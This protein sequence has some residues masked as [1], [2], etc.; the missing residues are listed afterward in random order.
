LV[1]GF[2]GRAHERDQFDRLAAQAVLGRGNVIVVSGEAGVGKTSLLD[3]AVSSWREKGFEVYGSGAA[4]IDQRRRFGLIADALRVRQA[5]DP[6][7]AEISRIVHASLS[8]PPSGGSPEPEVLDFQ[9]AERALSYIEERAVVA[10]V[11]LV[12]E[13]LQWADTS[14]LVAVHRLA[15]EAEQLRLLLV[16]TWLS[17][18]RAPEARPFAAAMRRLGATFFELKPLADAEV[19]QL[20]AQETG[21]PGGPRLLHLLASANGNP[22]YIKELVEALRSDGTLVIGADGQAEVPDGR[23]PPSLR[24]AVQHRL[25][26]LPEPTLEILRTASVLGVSFGADEL[27]IVHGR[28][29]PEVLTVL[30]P[31]LKGGVLGETEA[32]LAFRHELVRSAVY[33]DVP[34]SL[35][36]AQHLDA[37]RLLEAADAPAERVAFHLLLGAEPGDRAAVHWLRRAARDL[38]SRSPGLAVELLQRAR[39]ICRP[40]DPAQA[41]LLMEMVHPLASTGR[42]QE[43]ESL[44]RQGL[45]GEGR[46]EDEMVFRMGLGHSLFIQGRIMEARA[47]YQAAAEHS[48][49]SEAD[50]TVLDAYA[51]LT[52]AYVG[53]STTLER[54]QAATA[55]A[56]S[57]VAAGIF[58]LAVATSDLHGGRTDRAAAIIDRLAA[59]GPSNR[60]G[61]QASRGMALLDLDDVGGARTVLLEGARQTLADGTAER[62]AIHHYQL[63]AAEY[64][65]GDFDAAVAQHQ[66]GLALAEGSGH[67]WRA[68]NLGLVA[69]I[70]VHRGDF[71]LAEETLRAA[72]EEMA[73]AGPNPGDEEVARARCLLAQANG[74]LLGAAAAAQE[75]WDRCES[76]GYRAHL[77]WF[78]VEV[79]RTALAAGDQRRAADVVTA[80]ELAAAEAPAA[81]WRACAVWARGLLDADHE[82][83][84]AA[85]DSLRAS[86]RRVYLAL[87]LA[88]AAVTL[89]GHGDADAARQLGFEASDLFAGMDARTDSGRLH[90][91]LRSA[92]LQ[93]G[94]RA[95]RGR[96]RSGWGSLSESELKV[97]RLVADG[98]TNRDIADRLFLSRDTVHTHVSHVLAKLGLSSRVELAAQAARRGL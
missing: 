43:L 52:G 79:V 62:A 89:A 51:A 47:A 95:R 74:D 20:V 85:V 15:R 82:R 92:G 45:R 56:A 8:E 22:L 33:E 54:A 83:L 67:H 21:A 28:A 91:R 12:F 68:I 98:R 78:A 23:L 17:R 93:L 44:C 60:W 90:K 36:R 59:A 7:R 57:P 37:A 86:P 32:G 55:S 34:V 75:A 88:D 11:A 53:E 80:A 50:R 1:E 58:Y 84:L 63:V 35:R 38:E 3:V 64:A 70:A 87:A 16:C 96:P 29:L 30:R 18:S 13:D 48:A 39:A 76:H 31:A 27:R 24:Q 65:V 97:V 69:A 6:E 72:A 10:P 25:A 5:R 77:P 66:A 94:A 40:D 2:I 42:Q 9:V 41:E 61:L 81:C 14:S 71:S 73:S 46:P 26:G 49:L 4:A 19:A